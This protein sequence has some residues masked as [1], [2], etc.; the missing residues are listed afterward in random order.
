MA[1]SGIVKDNGDAK[2]DKPA[3]G[4]KDSKPSDPAM[5]K[6]G[7]VNEV[8]LEKKF[9][10]D[11]AKADKKQ[12]K[13]LEKKIEKKDDKDDARTMRKSEAKEPTEPK[14]KKGGDVKDHKY[15][16]KAHHYAEGGSVTGFGC[17]PKMNSN[18]GKVNKERDE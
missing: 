14:F 11:D 7:K 17:M 9:L 4:M 6:G 5:K 16:K 18:M 8:K 15:G 13:A 1:A 12:D 3:P 10:K 2:F